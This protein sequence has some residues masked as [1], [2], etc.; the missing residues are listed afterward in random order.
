MKK[1][2]E[3]VYK[4]ILQKFI[5]EVQKQTKNQNKDNNLWLRAVE[6]AFMTVNKIEKKLE[7]YDLEGMDLHR[8]WSLLSSHR[9]SDVHL[10]L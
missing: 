9:S 6:E 2:V 5:R 10:A 1:L 8:C 3:R 4:R 7:K